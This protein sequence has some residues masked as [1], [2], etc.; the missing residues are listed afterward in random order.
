M[1]TKTKDTNTARGVQEGTVKQIIGAVVDVHFDSYI[2]EVYTAL[3][4]VSG[5]R[6]TAE[7]QR[8]T[9]LETASHL[10]GG[11]VRAHPLPGCDRGDAGGA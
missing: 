3:Q 9:V 6:G 4:V 5:D 8:V 10:G 1:Q 7:K 2:P 11:V